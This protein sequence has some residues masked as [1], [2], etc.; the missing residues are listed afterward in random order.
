MGKSDSAFDVLVIGGGPG[1]YVAALRAAQLG[2]R[3]ALVEREHLGGICLNWGCIPTKSLLHGADTL[4]RIRQAGALGIRVAP[5]EV[6]FPAMIGR[7]RAVATKLSQGIAGLLKKAGVQVHE[8]H[9]RFG[10]D[11]QMR[12]RRADGSELALSARH[13][14]L[15]TGARAREL[16]LMRFDGDRVWSY[17][18]ALSARRLPA[19]LVVAGAGAI[20]LEFASFYAALGT[21]VTVVEAQPRV[22]PGGDADVSRFMEKALKQ[23]GMALRTGS[24][25]KQVQRLESGVRVVV[26]SSTG[27]EVLEADHLLVAIGLVGNTED[28]GLEHTRVHCERG[29]I[30]VDGWGATAHAGIHA[31]GDVTGLPMLA[32]RAMHQGVVVAERIAGLRAHGSA[33]HPAIPACTYGHPHTAALGLNE[34]QARALGKPVRVGR[35]PLEGNGKAVAVGEASGF[36]KTIF[37][38]A[39]GALLGAHIIGAEAT[40]MIQGFA[41]AMGLEST[42]AELMETVFP[43]PTVSESMHESVLSAYGLALHI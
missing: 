7:S 10:A 23:D 12:V 24:S 40:E 28:L 9:A 42:E 16:P 30:A 43:H 22:L 20:G 25:V 6:D 41:I 27:E 11:A 2:L 37:D 5:P 13:H 4:R 32:H 35:F 31:I 15:A 17:R 14:V 8:G 29:L 33:P 36:V 21:Q 18:D 3:T 1:G 38:E 39:S 26:A 34:D 19:S